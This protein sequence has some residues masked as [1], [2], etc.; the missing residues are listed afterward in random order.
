MRLKKERRIRRS[1]GRRNKTSRAPVQRRKDRRRRPVVK[2]RWTRNAWL[3]GRL[4]GIRDSVKTPEAASVS[5]S[6]WLDL[7]GIP[8]SE[9][10]RLLPSLAE[11]FRKGFVKGSRRPLPAPLLPASKKRTSVVVPAC[12]EASELPGVIRELKRMRLHEI[13]VVVN[14]STDGSFEAARSF[15]GITV[16]NVPE[17]LGH[18]VARALGARISTGDTVLFVDG[19]MAVPASQLCAFIAASDRGVD[20]AL[21][22]VT[23]LLP[24]FSRQDDV[25]RCK[26]FLNRTL[27]RDDLEANSLTAVPH[28][29]TRRAIETIGC[30]ALAVPPKAHALALT[31]GLRVEGVHTVDVL[32]VNRRRKNNRGWDNPVARLIIGDHIEALGELLDK[33]GPRLYWGQISRP[34]LAERRNGL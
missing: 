18:D 30:A 28:S 25:T 27:N 2:S 20:V 1:N 14:G 13:I 8:A 10:L 16:V 4:A 3:A 24:S 5:L 7:S 34:A 23:P 17:R 26:S 6:E 21:N 9:Q 32:S 33:Q 12:N 22:D 31:L 15:E 11:S 19:D 29:L